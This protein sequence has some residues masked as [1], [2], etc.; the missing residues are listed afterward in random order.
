MNCKLP[1]T[2][3]GRL[4][5]KGSTSLPYIVKGKDGKPHMM[6]GMVSASTVAWIMYQK[7]CN[8]NPLY[9]QEK[10]RENLYGLKVSRATFA[11]WVIDITQTNSSGPFTAS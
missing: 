9:R 3:R 2:L 7:Y 5:K 6:K 1:I 4:G 11:N 10:E 8:S